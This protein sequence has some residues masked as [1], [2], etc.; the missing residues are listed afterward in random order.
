MILNPLDYTPVQKW[1]RLN[2]DSA[3]SDIVRIWTDTDSKRRPNVSFTAS[4]GSTIHVGFEADCS[5]LEAKSNCWQA[6]D[7]ETGFNAEDSGAAGML[8]WDSM[9]FIY[10]L[11]KDYQDTLFK[12]AT[13]LSTMLDDFEDKFAP[14]PPAPDTMWIDFMIDLITLGTVSAWG[15]FI[16]RAIKDAKLVVGTSHDDLKEVV[17][18][19]LSMSGTI[20]KDLLPIGESN[21]PWSLEKQKS[22]TAYMGQVIGIWANVT[23][24]SLAKIFDGT[25]NSVTRLGDM[26]SGGQL[27]GSGKAQDLS[28]GETAESDLRTNVLKTV[29]GF[30]IPALWYVLPLERP[31]YSMLMPESAFP[32]AP[33]LTKL[34]HRSYSNAHAFVIDSG[35]GCGEAKEKLEKYID[36]ETADATGVCIDS[37]MYYLGRADGKST[38]CKCELTDH[39][40]CQTTCRDKKFTAPPGVEELDGEQFGGIKLENLVKGSVNTYNQNG[41]KNGGAAPNVDDDGMY[42][43]AILFIPRD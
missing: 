19:T 42:S 39:G 22:F 35:Y 32:F 15:T 12:A 6:R 37:K 1:Q 14:V 7:C 43:S 16:Q 25:D 17:K 29:F 5:I 26:M 10:Q 21:K 8:I 27:L 3:W 11:H 2:A 18:N 30:G 38:E 40:P 13:T 9:V 36:G 34:Y 20:T 24:V 4:V 23:A 41:G 28:V 33:L 31:P